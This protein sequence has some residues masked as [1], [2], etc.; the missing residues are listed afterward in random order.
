M[1]SDKHIRNLLKRAKFKEN[2]NTGRLDG[3][4]AQGYV[5]GK[6]NWMKNQVRDI[7]EEATPLRKS[8]RNG[9]HSKRSKAKAAKIHKT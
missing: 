4:R 8:E 2:G 1:L 5:E 7:K 9:P 3:G 6:R